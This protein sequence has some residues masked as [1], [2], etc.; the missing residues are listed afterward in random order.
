MPLL[1]RSL[2]ALEQAEQA[3]MIAKRY[4]WLDTDLRRVD[5][6]LTRLREGR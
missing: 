4:V 2:T 1:R 5:A 3:L 6:A